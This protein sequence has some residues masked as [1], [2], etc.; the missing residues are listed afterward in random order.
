[1]GADGS[2]SS[3]AAVETAARKARRHRA[4]LR[5]VYA[6]QRKGPPGQGHPQR[7]TGV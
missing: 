3:L 6:L 4:E 5:L 7:T 1:M 2:S